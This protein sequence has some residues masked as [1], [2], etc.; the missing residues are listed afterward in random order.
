MR[1]A[2]GRTFLR[3]GWQVATATNG[4]EGLEAVRRES[5]DIIISDL[6]MPGRGGLWLYENA[7]ALRPE[8]RGRFV[9][10]SS[11]P[12]PEPRSMS[13][14]VGAARFHLKPVTLETLWDTAR[15]ITRDGGVLDSL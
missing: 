10:I 15:E 14:F 7:V 9:L 3:R 2:I 1:A 6:N 4:V 12:L 13:I 8:L 11:E 5:F